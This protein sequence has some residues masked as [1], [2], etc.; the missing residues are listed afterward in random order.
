MSKSHDA[1]VAFKRSLNVCLSLVNFTN[2]QEHTHDLFVCA[3][4]QQARESA[5]TVVRS[6]SMGVDVVGSNRINSLTRPGSARLARSCA[7]T[8]SSC[9]FVG[10]IP[11][12][13]R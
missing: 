4:I 5:E 3:T 12:Q 8:S 1:L 9:D 7:V 6:T 11:Y 13:S 2:F 10:R